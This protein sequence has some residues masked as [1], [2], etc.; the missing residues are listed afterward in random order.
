[1]TKAEKDQLDAYLANKSIEAETVRVDSMEVS[2]K[3][4]A[5]ALIQLGVVNKV[6]LIQKIK[7][8][9]MLIP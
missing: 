9:K 4:L 8:N 5:R 7:E 6:A 2:V 1:M 3:E